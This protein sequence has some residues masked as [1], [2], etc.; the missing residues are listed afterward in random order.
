MAPRVKTRLENEP[1]F[2]LSTRGEASD[3]D[4]GPSR[5]RPGTNSNTEQRPTDMT[6]I[7]NGLVSSDDDRRNFIKNPEE[8][9]I[10]TTAPNRRNPNVSDLSLML[11]RTEHLKTNPEETS[12][13]P[14]N[15]K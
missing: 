15:H 14:P 12:M 5:N 1:L 4:Q 13:N 3:F 7:I 6:V 9:Q 10:R 2:G 11:A 8:T